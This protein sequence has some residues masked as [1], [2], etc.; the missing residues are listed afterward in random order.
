MA[1]FDRRY[2]WWIG[3][4]VAAIAI[5]VAAWFL[6]LKPPTT[7]LEESPAP[8]VEAEEEVTVYGVEPPVQWAWEEMPWRLLAFEVPQGH[9][10]YFSR[11]NREM[12]VIPG[13]PLPLGA[14][15]PDEDALYAE[16]VLIF[17]DVFFNK[18]DFETWE[19]FARTMAE[20][21]CARGTGE[22]DYELCGSQVIQE[23][24]GTSPVGPWYGFKLPKRQYATQASLG[25]VSFRMVRLGFQEGPY[26]VLFYAVDPVRGEALLSQMVQRLSRTA[27]I[28][29]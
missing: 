20:F 14:P 8:S 4:G 19:G 1:L 26:S 7:P 13:E 24:R 21:G 29:E 28:D 5:A 16:A 12:L 15:A 11:W 17:N 6:W 25:F 22:E 2:W 9:W 10:V 23:T 3:G 18:D 27:Q